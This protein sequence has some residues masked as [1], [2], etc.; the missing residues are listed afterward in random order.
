MVNVFQSELENLIVILI[1]R[2]RYT[3]QFFVVLFSP[4]LEFHKMTEWYLPVL[5]LGSQK[6]KQEL[7]DSH[8]D[9]MPA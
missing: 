7:S 1:I 2:S 5:L 4:I 9:R 6:A 3:L 8:C